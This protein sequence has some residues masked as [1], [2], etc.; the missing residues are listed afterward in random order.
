M[1][2]IDNAI[3]QERDVSAPSKPNEMGTAGRAISR[4]T[5]VGSGAILAAASAAGVGTVLHAAPAHAEETGEDVIS[6]FCATNCAGCCNLRFHVKDGEILYVET[7]NAGSS[8]F[9]SLQARACLKG[10]SHREWLSHPDRLNYPMRRAGARGSGEF[11]RI[12][13]DEAL[14]TVAS[15]MKRIRSTYGSESIAYLS[16][17]YANN[18]L[19][20]A[21]NVVKRMLALTGGYLNF[22]STS[23][24]STGQAKAA[25]LYTYGVPAPV[26]GSTLRNADLEDGQIIIFFGNAVG[27]A[28]LSG[29]GFANEV[30]VERERHNLRCIYVDPRCSAITTNQDN[31]WIPIRPGTD[32]A[33]VA[34]IA[35]VLITE[36]LADEDFLHTYCVGYDE[37]TLPEGAPANSS[38]WA[39]VMGTGYDEVEKTPA[40]ASRITQIP[41][42]RIIDLAHELAS[43]PRVF[44]TQGFGVARRANGE[45][46]SRSIMLLAMLLGQMGVP[47]THD[48]RELGMN[49]YGIA[50]FPKGEN[51]CKISLPTYLWPTAVEAPS[52]INPNEHDLVG[53]ETFPGIKMIVGYG[54][55]ILTNQHGDVQRNHRILSDESACE[56]IVMSEL[57][58][59][60]ACK[61]AD[62]LLP[63]L[64]AQELLNVSEAGFQENARMVQFARPI[65]DSKFERRDIYEVCA[66][67]CDRFGVRDEFTQGK[68]REEWVRELYEAGREKY[69]Q[70]PTWD[71]GFK[72]GIFKE[73]PPVSVSQEKFIADPVANPL[74]TPSGKIEIY[75]GRLAALE[76]KR[77]KAD[78]SCSIAPVPVY[79]PA[80]NGFE[81]CTEEYPLLLSDYHAAQSV[82]SSLHNVENLNRNF[83]CTL[84]VNPVDAEP[85]GIASGDT[86]LVSNDIGKILIEARVTQRVI[87]GTVVMPQGMLFDGSRGDGIDAGACVNTLCTSRPSLISL[88][89]PSHSNICQIAKYEEA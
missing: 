88:N 23:S 2:E 83:R 30:S 16:I 19:M 9:G 57:F 69:P 41:E 18:G 4:R 42:Q 49:K 89:N 47:G 6:T 71:E 5:F 24:Y 82:N 56:F 51:P 20:L 7:D 52:S 33:L 31:E 36:G 29:V 21:D 87:P 68:T 85:R 43:A 73:E 8:E 50:A 60:D 55:S 76:Q 59:T 86:V 28:R 74:P 27:D 80:F 48:G 3:S 70:L 12:S 13:W 78:P 26:G 66:D 67:L 15:E 1:R 17:W 61:Y 62:I 34:G 58:M 54:A 32:A 63:D 14:D 45:Q 40:W 35:H 39:Y 37:D 38:Y 10:R 72:A 11:E 77:Q 22:P 81:D 25:S 53:A 44:V 75:S 46:N 79:D 64:A 84:W 65:Y